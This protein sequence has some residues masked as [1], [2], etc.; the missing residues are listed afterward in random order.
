MPLIVGVIAAFLAVDFAHPPAVGEPLPRSASALSRTAPARAAQL[1]GLKLAAPQ[2]VWMQGEFL[3]IDGRVEPTKDDRLCT[4]ERGVL[5]FTH[6]PDVDLLDYRQVSRL[7]AV[8][9][10]D[11]APCGQVKAAPRYGFKAASP[12]EA[13]VI[14]GFVVQLLEAVRS[15]DSQ[16]RH[17]CLSD[18]AVCKNLSTLSPANFREYM[19]GGCARA[20]GESSCGLTFVDSTGQEWLVWISATDGRL[21][22][23]S[24]RAVQTVV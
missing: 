24:A 4:F 6:Y 15:H 2:R 10:S 21:T 18:P 12:A 16:V 3:Y 17:E 20:V 19:S 7:Y 9:G 22:S 1:V 13:M 23:A 11:D 5:F 14:G 8:R